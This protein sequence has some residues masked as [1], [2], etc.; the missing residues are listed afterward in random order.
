MGRKEIVK[1]DGERGHVTFRGNPAG[2]GLLGLSTVSY[3]SKSM[4][5]PIGPYFIYSY[6]TS[7]F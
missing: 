2:D 5:P 1:K 6:V 3:A 7:F 4:A